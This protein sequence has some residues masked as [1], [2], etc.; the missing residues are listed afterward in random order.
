[1]VVFSSVEFIFR[2]MPVFMIIYWIAP[3]AA[4]KYIPPAG[5]D[6]L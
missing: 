1:M 6:A 3:G 5:R 4:K 2:F